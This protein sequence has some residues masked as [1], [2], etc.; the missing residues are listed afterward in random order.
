M[1]PQTDRLASHNAATTLACALCKL[2]P[3]AACPPRHRREPC[4]P[5]DGP[6][7]RWCLSVHGDRLRRRRPELPS[8]ATTAGP[9]GAA[10]RM[11]SNLTDRPAKPT[12]PTTHVRTH[13]RI[14]PPTST[15]PAAG[16]PGV[17][18]PANPDSVPLAGL[19][20]TQRSTSATASYCKAS[21]R[22]SGRNLQ[23]DHLP[24]CRCDIHQQQSHGAGDGYGA[25]F[26]ECDV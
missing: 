15:G 2:Q 3:S 13:H 18:L 23:N 24:Q 17:G 10:S 1:F 22:R 12:N 11:P 14:R 8:T 7:R 16:A 9:S 20:A 4:K 6:T 25:A 19:A 26:Y 21:R 5:A